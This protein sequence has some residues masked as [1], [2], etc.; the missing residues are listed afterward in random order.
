M[1]S[2]RPDAVF[3]AYVSG[4]LCFADAQ[5]SGIAR[6]SPSRS[7]FQEPAILDTILHGLQ[8]QA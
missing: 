4:R 8:E 6:G 7:L 5:D 3:V 2:V 1:E